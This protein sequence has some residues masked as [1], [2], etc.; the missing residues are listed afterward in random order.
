MKGNLCTHKKRFLMGDVR[1]TRDPENPGISAS[2]SKTLS[3]LIK[4]IKVFLPN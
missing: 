2:E 1:I 3:S 4:E